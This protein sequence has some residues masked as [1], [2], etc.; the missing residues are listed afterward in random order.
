MEFKPFPKI[1]R[2]TREVA[3]T[4]KLDGTNAQVF[5]RELADDEG[6]PRDTPIVEAVGKLVIYAGSRTLWIQPGKTDN[7]GFAAWVKE[8]AEELALLGPGQHFGEW[9]GQGIK[10]NY[11]LTEKRFSLFNVHKWSEIRPVCCGV[12]PVLWRGMFNTQEIQNALDLLNVNGSKAAPGFMKPE[13][14]V[15]F[16]TAS[17]SLFKK[18]LCKDEEYKGK[19]Q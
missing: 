4:E 14:V 1:S 2:L 8:H 5:I 15:I 10:R 19:Q 7:Y 17:N 11:G 16:H 13:G 12:V 18:T 3:I 9:W 6:M